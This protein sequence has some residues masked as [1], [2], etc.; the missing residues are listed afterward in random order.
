M[1]ETVLEGVDAEVG[2]CGLET[3]L[4]KVTLLTHVS[5]VES[6]LFVDTLLE[7]RGEDAWG[8]K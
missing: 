6:L 7:A 1:E 3:L 2:C 8:V 4:L 5:L